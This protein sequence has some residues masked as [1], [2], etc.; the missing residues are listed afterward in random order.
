MAAYRRLGYQVGA[1]NQYNSQYHES[2][3]G[4]CQVPGGGFVILVH[5]EIPFVII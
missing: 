2:E 5:V 4:E 1:N 3:E